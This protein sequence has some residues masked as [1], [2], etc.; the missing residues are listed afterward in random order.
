MWWSWDFYLI[1]D[2]QQKIYSASYNTAKIN[3]RKY[4]IKQTVDNRI[5]IVYYINEATTEPPRTLHQGLGIDELWG[6][7]PKVP[8]NKAEKEDVYEFVSVML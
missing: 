8:L 2:S 5:Q 1:K 4:I 7:I 6:F 3:L